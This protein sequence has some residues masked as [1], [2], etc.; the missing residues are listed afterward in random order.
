ML[1]LLLVLV[2]FLISLVLTACAELRSNEAPGIVNPE[3]I[4]KQ[5]YLGCSINV[6]EPV[7]VSF[8][9]E[10]RWKLRV[11]PDEIASNETFAAE[12]T[13]VGSLAEYLFDAGQLLIEGGFKTIQVV[14]LQA[15]VHIRRGATDFDGGPPDVIL[16]IDIDQE[17]TCTYDATGKTGGAG[18]FPQCSK[19]NDNPEDGS[20]DDCTGFGGMGMPDPAN[21]CGWLVD[22]PT[23]SDC[24]FC[25][26]L[27]K[28]TSTA[29]CELNGFCVSGPATVP[30]KGTLD[31]FRADD[32]GHVFFGWDDRPERTGATI[33]EDGGCND[34]TWILPSVAF[35]DPLGPTA[36]RLIAGGIPIAFE[37]TMGV[38]SRFED[39]VMS[40]DA[41]ASPTPD[42]RLI[43][44]PIQQP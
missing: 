40:C 30:L 17:P 25:D 37:C 3:A 20:N 19:E 15:T 36:I 4:E 28:P 7:P 9:G 18:P 14:E 44:F 35:D 12:L 32:Q 29:Q 11:D 22:I 5:I 34:G 6:D 31:G 41:L 43:A 26:S 21:R 23:S 1:R 2:S 8:G 13:A 27:E 24:A 33:R 42:H 39:G 16:G 10:L 38:P